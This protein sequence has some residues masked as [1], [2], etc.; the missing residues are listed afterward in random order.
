MKAWKYGLRTIFCT[1]TVLCMMAVV[2]PILTQ[3]AYNEGDIAGTTG[4]GTHGDP[5]ICNTFKELKNALEEEEIEYIELKNAGRSTLPYKGSAGSDSAILVVGKY[6]TL[7]ITGDSEFVANG[8]KYLIHVP[9]NTIFQINGDGK[10]QYTS[11]MMHNSM[12]D[13]PAVFRIGGWCTMSEN[14]ELVGEVA[15]PTNTP[16]TLGV[17]VIDMDGGRL[18][19]SDNVTCRGSVYVGMNDKYWYRASDI[20]AITVLNGGVMN[21][22][23]GTFSMDEKTPNVSQYPNPTGACGLYLLY[24]EGSPVNN[25]KISGGSFLGISLKIYGSAGIDDLVDSSNGTVR[26]WDA[27]TEDFVNCEEKNSPSEETE[28]KDGLAIIIYRKYHWIHFMCDKNAMSWDL[29]IPKLILDSDVQM[30]TAGEEI[31]FAA[32]ANKLNSGYIDNGYTVYCAVGLY[33]RTD[34]GTKGKLLKMNAAT[35]PE[36]TAELSYTF[37]EKTSNRYILT[38]ALTLKDKA[39]NNCYMKTMDIDVWINPRIQINPVTYFGKIPEVGDV[40]SNPY[41]YETEQYTLTGEWKLVGTNGEL[42]DTSTFFPMSTY[43]FIAEAE[44]KPGYRFHEEVSF[45][46]IDEDTDD[47]LTGEWKQGKTD[48]SWVKVQC[49]ITLPGVIDTINADLP[50]IDPGAHPANV[51]ISG[52]GVVKAKSSLWYEYDVTDGKPGKKLDP[53]SDTFVEGK[54]YLLEVGFQADEGYVFADNAACFLS[55]QK[56]EYDYRFDNERRI[57]YK[58]KF[59]CLKEARTVEFSLPPFTDGKTPAYYNEFLELFE[60]DCPGSLKLVSIEW[61]DASANNNKL[62]D[63]DAFGKNQRYELIITMEPAGDLCKIH[64]EVTATLNDSGMT[65]LSVEDKKLIFCTPMFTQTELPS[66]TIGLPTTTVNLNNVTEEMPA[67]IVG[68]LLPVPTAPEGTRIESYYWETFNWNTEKYEK[69]TETSYTVKP[70]ELYYCHVI[71]KPEMGYFFGIDSHKNVSFSGGKTA[72]SSSSFTDDTC[73]IVSAPYNPLVNY[74]AV[75]NITEPVIGDTIPAAGTFGKLISA[76]SKFKKIGVNQT[77]YWAQTGTFIAGESYSLM[78]SFE[79]EGISYFTT[80]LKL[81]VNGEQVETNNTPASNSMLVQV[82]YFAKEQQDT[83]V[84]VYFKDESLPLVGRSLIVDVAKTVEKAGENWQMAYLE[85]EL[86]YQWFC[87]G[88]PVGERMCAEE[89]EISYLLTIKEWESTIYA[90]LYCNGRRAVSDSFFIK[91]P[92]RINVQVKTPVTGENADT[93]VINSSKVFSVNNVSWKNNGTVFTGTFAGG[94]VYTINITGT[95]KSGYTPNE[96]DFS[97]NGF[98]VIPTIDST[99]GTVTLRYEFPITQAEEDTSGVTIQGTVTTYGA[100]SE[101]KVTLK[102]ADTD[103]TFE[104]QTWTGTGGNG[105]PVTYSFSN[106]PT[107][108]YIVTVEKVNHVAREYKISVVD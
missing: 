37:M 6:K 3:A 89:D 74:I 102:A 10:L 94:E 34:S 57:W 71:L 103:S 15:A 99:D 18:D 63:T 77:P 14:V 70:D 12:K 19:I 85:G 64:D 54:I 65:T 26:I 13:S 98:D 9:K 46:Y 53:S 105:T 25:I 92:A 49:E 84:K 83:S 72:Q 52:S 88:Y 38:F 62:A 82:W 5:V 55:G 30:Y 69:V 40:C 33:E 100:V 97:I 16:Y 20:A 87:D 60:V 43:R 51:T 29:Q 107:G 93:H 104:T 58:Y 17:R 45:Y 31:T 28:E 41:T 32:S 8:Q 48:N 44:S 68:E 66:L 86:E 24:T 61:L 2:L 7:T 23:G 96:F 11:S 101:I 76:G 106:I 78:M 59:H 90:E 22:T 75:E 1:V 95:L 67:L 4:T 42:Y 108:T 27:Y 39:G 80:D 73:N 36:D 47:R 50:S 21:I 81:T 56:A 35:D 91:L 79:P